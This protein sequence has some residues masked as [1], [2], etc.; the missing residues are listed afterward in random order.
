MAVK[1][2]S[3]FPCLIN[4]VFLKNRKKTGCLLQDSSEHYLTCYISLF[5]D[6]LKEQYDMW[7]NLL[8]P[9]TGCFGKW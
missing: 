2:E 8:G 7:P 3:R 5:C 4:S 6:F 9:E 1:W